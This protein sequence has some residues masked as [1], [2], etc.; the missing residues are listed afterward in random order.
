MTGNRRTVFSWALYDFANSPF[1]TIVVTFVYA[2]YFTQAIVTDPIHGTALWSRAVTIS[3]LIVALSSPVLGAIADCGFRKS[4]LFVTTAVCVVATAALYPVRPGQ[5]A[6]AL[7]LFIVA[8]VAFELANVFYNAYLPDIAPPERIGRISG[9]GWG[10]GYVGGLLSLV[11]ALL[12]LVLPETPMFGLS[13][14]DGQNIRATNLLVAGWFALFS[15][16]TF[17]WVR[18][19]ARP[20]RAPTRVLSAGFAELRQT[21][22]DIGR[23]RQIVRLLTARLVYNDGLV[24]IFAFGAIYAASTFGFTFTEVMLFGIVLNVAAGAGAFAM[25]YLD[26][27]MGGKFT[28]QVTLVGL[29]VA[30][31]IAVVAPNK[32]WLWVAGVLVGI[33]VGPNQSASRSLMGRFVPAD[34]RNQFF[35]FYAFSGKLTAF[36]GPLLLGILTQSTGSQRAGIGIVLVLFIV[37]FAL[38]WRVDEREGL[39][40]A[41]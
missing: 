41:G 18:D 2:T 25:G 33:F 26:D 30:T 32:L 4:M 1:T 35:G 15:I 17:L 10:L 3:A 23:Y 28:I 27:R 31:L 12:L 14:H 39:D 9:I 13:T 34:S 21:F 40:A 22:R 38:L 7:T 24:T 37:G 19:R 36:I 8:N 29:I 5:V 11:L 16:P 6:L 20:A